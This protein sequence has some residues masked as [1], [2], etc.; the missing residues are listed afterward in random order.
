MVTG[1]AGVATLNVVLSLRRGDD[2]YRIIGVDSDKF[3]IFLTAGFDKKYLVPRAEEPNYVPVINEIIEAEG[4]Q[5]LHP[6]PDLEV[7]V[8]SSRRA[9]IGAKMMLPSADV[10]E[11]CHDKYAFIER[12][13]EH[14]IPSA[15][16][17]LIHSEADLE[18]AMCEL[19]P[20]VWLR[21]IRGAAGHGS[22]PVRSSSHGCMWIDYW[23][24]WGDFVAEE[25]LPG[26]NVAWE[27]VYENGQ[28]LGSIAYERIRY[29]IEQVS[30][31]GITGT[32]AVAK[33]INDEEVHRIGRQTVETLDP[34]PTGIFGVDMK[35]S[36]EG[37]F[38]VT[39]IN[40]GRFN[41]PS[42]MFACGGYNLVRMFF[43][44]ACGLPASSN[45][46]VRARVD[47]NFYWLRGVDVPPVARAI[48]TFPEVGTA[49][50]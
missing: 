20:K 1:C 49:C 38:C 27:G 39:E 35:E 6:Q 9:D 17:I 4:V 29:M 33:L 34:E 3:S 22:L 46:G 21:A 12:L 37:I 30:P 19:G 41:Q 18:A 31:S 13:R 24:G 44:S 23:D 11:L 47:G 8:L 26:R 15:R 40:P 14:K 45:L 48:E 10:I 43:D 2:A 36:S 5:F 16:H 7:G 42:Y 28:L 50:E 32:P 25:Y